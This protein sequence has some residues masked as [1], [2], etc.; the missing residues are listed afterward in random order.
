MRVVHHDE[1]YLGHFTFVTEDTEILVFML[2]WR[3]RF[4]R[5][6]C[7][8]WQV[9]KTWSE[10][11][12]FLRFVV[13]VLSVMLGLKHTNALFQNQ[14]LPHLIQTTY[15]LWQRQNRCLYET[16]LHLNSNSV[17]RGPSVLHQNHFQVSNY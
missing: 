12:W 17:R 9:Q 14:I 5:C 13:S 15:F 16:Q 2:R 10:V 3:L 6:L 8:S 1:W 4:N 7:N 11:K